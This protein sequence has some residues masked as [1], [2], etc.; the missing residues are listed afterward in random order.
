MTRGAEMG[1]LLTGGAGFIGT[2]LAERLACWTKV[3]LLDS[4]RRNALSYT[5]ELANHPNIAVRTGNVLDTAAL[6]EAL[7]GIETVVHL[8]AIA[9]VSSYYDRS[10]ET[11]QVNILGTTNVLEAAAKRGV[12]RFVYFST[13]EVYGQNA[14][15]VNEGD[16]LCIGSPT[17]R[18]WVYAASKL[19]GEHLTLRSAEQYGL[20]C[21][22]VRPFNI[23]GPGQVGEGAIANFCRAVVDG[24]PMTVYG[25]GSAIRAWCYVSDL[26]DAVEVILREPSA[27]GG[28]FNIGNPRE[29]ETTLGLA[30]RLVR[31]EPAGTIQFE[32]MKHLEIR[33]RIPCIDQARRVLGFEPKVELD[34][35]LRWT[36]EWFRERKE[37]CS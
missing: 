8:A 2:R 17:D 1:V 3:V 29:V 6:D 15:W 23:Y 34:E 21:A 13:S 18:R 33:A 7:E 26:V 36:L 16:P 32:D 10:L 22:I 14:L 37:A 24:K 31:L 27:V 5:P 9:G 28:V 35:G 4:F 30:R 12:R 11:L 20:E 19:A 25:D